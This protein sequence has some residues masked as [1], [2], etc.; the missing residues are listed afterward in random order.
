MVFSS[1]LFVFLFLFFHLCLYYLIPGTKGKNIVLLLSSLLFYAWGGPRFLILLVFMTW[2]S[3]FCAKQLEKAEQQG[4]R[5]FWIVCDAVILLGMLF[6]F[7]YAGFVCETTNAFFSVPKVIPEI[8]LPI[9]ISFYTFQLLSYTVDVYRGK[10]KAQEKY[11]KLLLYSGLFHQCIAGPIVRY[12]WV[13]QDIDRRT[14]NAEQIYQGIRRFS[15]GLAK[16]AILANG[17]A[18]VADQLLPLTLEAVS[19]VS[20]SAIW[21]GMLFYMFQ[22]YLDFAAYSDMAIGMGKM[23]GF[24]YPENFDYPYIARSVQEFWRRWHISLGS[25]FRDYVYI[26]LGGSRRGLARTIINTFIVWGLTGLWHGASWN[27]LLWGLYF[28]LFLT[29]ERL[30]WGKCLEKVKPLGHI[31]LLAVIYFGWVLFKFEDFQVMTAVWK[32]MFHFGETFLS[33]EVSTILKN[34]LYFMIIC[35]LGSTPLFKELWKKITAVS[36]GKAWG[37]VVDCFDILVPP[38]LLILS[39]MALAGDSYNPFLYFQF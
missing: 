31:Y 9:G 12:E 20:P 26:P 13:E 19:A 23:V 4:K 11:W 33:L 10:V 3:W 8:V 2:V 6:V 14:V 29:I 30:G 38:V 35:I 37:I 21:I 15:I 17:C 16:K 28:F 25:F 7:K 5:K 27:Y 32:R 24:R 36:E 39:L 18:S 22:I 1:L 34:Q